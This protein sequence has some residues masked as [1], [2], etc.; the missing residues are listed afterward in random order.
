M[1]IDT[2]NISDQIIEFDAD[3]KQK[4]VVGKLIVVR[5]YPLDEDLNSYPQEKLNRNVYAYNDQG[6]LAWQIQEAPHGD[7][8]MDKAYMGVKVK[9]DILV[10]E[11]WIGVDYSVNL[12]DGTVKPLDKNV[13]PW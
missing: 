1:R 11:N 9:N 8:S 10:A 4:L 2:L 5:V 13:R 3:V 12:K 7:V 6:K